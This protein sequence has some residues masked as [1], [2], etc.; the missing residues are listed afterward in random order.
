MLTRCQRSPAPNERSP[1]SSK[2]WE[3][4][5]S[6]SPAP[7]E[8]L[9]S[10]V[11]R[12]EPA[13]QTPRKPVAAQPASAVKAAKSSQLPRPTSTPA[14]TPKNRNL[15]VPSEEMHPAQHHASTAKPRE[16][17]R[18]LGFQSMGPHT[19]PPKPTSIVVNSGTPSK[20]PIPTTPGE[21]DKIQS[22]ASH[23]FS[24]RV[25]S[26]IAD[27]SPASSNI[28][29]SLEENLAADGRAL[30]KADEFTAPE[31]MGAKRKTAV[32]TGKMSRFSDAHMVS[33][34]RRQVSQLTFEETV[35]EDGLN[36]EPPFCIPRRSDPQARHTLEEEPVE[37]ICVRGRGKRKDEQ[38]KAHT[39]QD[40]CDGIERKYPRVQS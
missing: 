22:M 10:I 15:V 19:A 32:P 7:Q 9:A 11:E 35:Q 12:T 40:G 20:A 27:L 21:T 5:Q 38:T 37:A 8:N 16:E 6:Q 13:M 39:V 30:F 17:A 1:S 24:F 33:V 36:R 28:L 18:W 26:P 2:G 29:T 34:F 25:K 31:D 4:A 23:G 3:T 14:R